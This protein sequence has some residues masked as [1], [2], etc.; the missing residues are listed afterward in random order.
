VLIVLVGFGGIEIGS[1]LEW[2]VLRG[3]D[4]ELMSFELSKMLKDNV[5]LIP[6]S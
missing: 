5:I 4:C 3:S 6:F 1:R 2:I